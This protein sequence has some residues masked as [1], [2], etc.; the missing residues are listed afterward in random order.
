M[1]FFGVMFLPVALNPLPLPVL[2]LLWSWQIFDG[3]LNHQNVKVPGS[4]WWDTE[5]HTIHHVHVRHN[6]AEWEALD[7]FAGTLFTGKVDWVAYNEGLEKRE[8][9]SKKSH[10]HQQSLE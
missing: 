10:D 1:E 4:Q 2:T 7:K 3:V 5:Y 9:S 8:R 6:Y